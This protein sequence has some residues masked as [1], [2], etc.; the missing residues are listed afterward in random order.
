MEL[1]RFYLGF[2]KAFPF[3][4]NHRESMTKLTIFQNGRQDVN[5]LLGLDSHKTDCQAPCNPK[6]C[7][8]FFSWQYEK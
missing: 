8:F 3:C 5:Q 1:K 4:A 6:F 7:P 2:E